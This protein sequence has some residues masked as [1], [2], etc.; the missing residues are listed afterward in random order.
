M[1][2]AL[3]GAAIH[4]RGRSASAVAAVPSSSV[5][6]GRTLA[7]IVATGLGL[8]VIGAILWLRRPARS[9]D[10]AQ[11]VQLMN[12]PD[13]VTQPALSPDGHMLAFIRGYSTW[14]GD[15]Q[16]YVKILPDG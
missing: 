2:L 4:E 15:G 8:L 11:W 13:S 5:R 14:V 16:I 7:V 9:P 3:A 1:E 10:R 12:F 6:L